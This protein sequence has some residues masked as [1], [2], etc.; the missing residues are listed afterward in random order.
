[1]ILCQADK[2]VR[3]QRIGKILF[4]ADPNEKVS[5]NFLISIHRTGIQ[6]Y[7]QEILRNRLCLHNQFYLDD[8][9]DKYDEYLQNTDLF[10]GSVYTTSIKQG[11]VSLKF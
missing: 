4:Y 6:F 5:R 7:Y 2:L 9:S 1:M 11:A 3:M 8:I 10:D